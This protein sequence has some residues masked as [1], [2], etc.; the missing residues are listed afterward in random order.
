MIKWGLPHQIITRNDPKD[1]GKLTSL[2]DLIL[3]DLP[4]SGEGMFRKNRDGRNGWSVENVKLCAARQ[5][6]IIYG[7][8]DA[9][10]PGGW[11]IY[12]TCTFNTEE[13]EENVYRLSG[14]LG[15]DVIPVPVKPEWNITGALQHGLPAYRFFPHRTRGEGFFLALMRKK[16]DSKNSR[17]AIKTKHR[18]N[19]QPAMIP[20]EVKGLLS[21]PEKFVFFTRETTGSVF[22]VPAEVEDRYRFLS[23][24]LHPVS[25]G[26][27]LGEYKGRD[28]IP[29]ISLALST[30]M[31]PGAFPSAE[32]PDD[33][34]IR[35]L[36]KE[37]D[38]LPEDAPKGYI[39]VTCRQIPLGFV[40][41]IGNRT[42]NL[43][44]PEWRIRSLKNPWL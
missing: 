36:R 29:S 37:T 18:G 3:T 26:V 34:A 22:A 1:F 24:Q 14:E 39:L 13:N 21:E 7:V 10:R 43:Y 32:L 6:R 41:N 9:L 27:T 19:R 16:R 20:A 33:R 4:C 11:L 44:P 8:W 23:G 42:N 40:K 17:E 28:F 25:A 5:R 15:A 35:Y 12:S 30:E 2:F 38:V 31:N